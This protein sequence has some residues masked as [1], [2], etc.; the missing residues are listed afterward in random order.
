MAFLDRDIGIACRLER[1]GHSAFGAYPECTPSNSSSALVS[2][3]CS[4]YRRREK[5]PFFPLLLKAS[6]SSRSCFSTRCLGMHER[7]S[8]GVPAVWLPSPVDLW[9]TL[10]ELGGPLFLVTAISGWTSAPGMIP[11]LHARTAE[12]LAFALPIRAR[13]CK[14]KY[15]PLLLGPYR[16]GIGA[17]I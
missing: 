15:R 6:K 4:N 14:K 8:K 5:L 7:C 17:V 10:T 12:C 1:T 11:R 3:V 13:N 16:K 2:W 9:P